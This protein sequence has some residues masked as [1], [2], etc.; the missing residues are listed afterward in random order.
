M[1]RC[2]FTSSAVT[3]VSPKCTVAHQYIFGHVIRINTSK[4]VINSN[5]A[6]TDQEED[7]KKK[8][9]KLRVSLGTRHHQGKNTDLTQD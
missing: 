6:E 5:L 4:N 1:F 8:I 7:F 3:F 2:N 9:H